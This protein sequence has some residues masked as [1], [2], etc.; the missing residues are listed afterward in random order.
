MGVND[1]VRTDLDLHKGS[2]LG[3]GVY[4]FERSFP[5]IGVVFGLALLPSIICLGRLHIASK[6]IYN[7]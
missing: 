4:A 2:Y 5:R 3:I 6:Y 1:K 7:L